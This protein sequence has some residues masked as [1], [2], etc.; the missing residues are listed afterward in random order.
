M[1]ASAHTDG[2]VDI[3]IPNPDSLPSDVSDYLI[4][5]ASSRPTQG[6]VTAPDSTS[7]S[8]QPSWFALDDVIM[9]SYRF[10]ANYKSMTSMTY[11][12]MTYKSMTTRA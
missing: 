11:K 10:P 3:D 5:D 4:L 1:H 8:Q 7:R 2:S 9:V 6:T 12:S